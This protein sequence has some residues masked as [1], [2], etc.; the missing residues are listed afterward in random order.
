MSI[1]LPLSQEIQKGSDGGQ[2][3]GTG[4]P[5]SIEQCLKHFTMPEVLADPVDC[6]TCG[7]QTPTTRQHVVSRLPKV[8]VLHLKRFDFA[9]N[10]KIEEYVSFPAHGLNMGPYLPHWCE[11]PRAAEVDNIKP[12]TAV[13]A[14]IAPR[15]VY[16]LQST[17]NHY[18]TLQ[19]GHYYANIKVDQTW[20]HCNDSHVS[21][22]P[23]S[24]VIAQPAYMLFYALD[25]LNV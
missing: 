7:E 22:A 5:I 3:A 25:T 24:E 23:E 8:L 14:S 13:E 19:S 16:N 20:Y 21:C 18:G 11:I 15:I 4:E 1:S 10:R 12:P 17:V 2:L 9:G 6:P